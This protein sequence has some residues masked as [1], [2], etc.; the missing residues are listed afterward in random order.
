M[1]VPSIFTP[2]T[3]SLLNGKFDTMLRLFKCLNYFRLILG[4]L[5]FQSHAKFIYGAILICAIAIAVVASLQ[6]EKT[7]FIIFFSISN[8][9]VIQN[10]SCILK[11]LKFNKMIRTLKN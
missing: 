8:I 11:N 5:R 1:F 4:I 7:L 2:N 6:D 3:K 10:G 9:L